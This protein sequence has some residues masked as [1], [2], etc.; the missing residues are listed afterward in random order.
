[1][2]STEGQCSIN[3]KKEEKEKEERSMEEMHRK[4]IRFKARR[5]VVCLNLLANESQLL[6]FQEFCKPVAKHSDY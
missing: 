6:N 5:P 1:M 3:R 2:L 4:K